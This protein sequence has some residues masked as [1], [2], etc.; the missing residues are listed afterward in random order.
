VK[1]LFLII[2]SSEE[3]KKRGQLHF[4]AYAFKL[5]FT[6]MKSLGVCSFHFRQ[7]QTKVISRHLYH[8]HHSTIW[9]AG[10]ITTL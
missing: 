2:Y 7:L 1:H 5:I 4:M 8:V 3:E 10:I 9:A 6:T